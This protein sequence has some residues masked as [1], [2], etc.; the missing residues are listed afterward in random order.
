ML[1]GGVSLYLILRLV[2]LLNFI[3]QV[4]IILMVTSACVNI[5]VWRDDLLV[6]NV[7]G[8][9]RYPQRLL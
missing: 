2:W 4:G 5:L 3:K 9:R 6:L 1:R 7:P 8:D